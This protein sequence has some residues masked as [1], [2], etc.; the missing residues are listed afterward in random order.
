MRHTD[1]MFACVCVCVCVCV[2]THHCGGLAALMLHKKLCVCV[3]VTTLVKHLAI[4]HIK[5]VVYLMKSFRHVASVSWQ[6]H[7]AP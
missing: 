3:C 5:H 4:M 6:F 2:A 7:I 1:T